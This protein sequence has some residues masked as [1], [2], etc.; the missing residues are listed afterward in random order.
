M[1]TCDICGEPPPEGEEL[2]KV[3]LPHVGV[4]SALV[5]RA[6]MK[7]VLEAADEMG[8]DVWSFRD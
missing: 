8:L 7:A 5:C 2:E 6:C 4:Y 3:P 1:P